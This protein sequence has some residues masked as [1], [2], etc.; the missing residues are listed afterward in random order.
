M[1]L[2]VTKIIKALNFFRINTVHGSGI[3]TFHDTKIR[4][5]EALYTP[6]PMLLSQIMPAHMTIPTL[7]VMDDDLLLFT[8]AKLDHYQK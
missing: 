6:V 4:N 3:Y 8:I 2:S 7:T 5:P 1:L